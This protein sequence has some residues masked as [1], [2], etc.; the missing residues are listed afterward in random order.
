MRVRLTQFCV[1]LLFLLIPL[2]FNS[3][4]DDQQGA[5]EAVNAEQ[6]DESEYDDQEEGDEYAEDE[7][8]GDEYAEDEEG[9][10]YAEGNEE[11]GNEYANEEEGAGLDAYALAG[12]LSYQITDKATFNGRIDYARGKSGVFFVSDDGAAT[13]LLSVTGTVDYSLWENVISRLEV[14]WD[15]AL[16]GGSPFGGFEET[17]FSP[18]QEENAVTI[19]LNAIYQF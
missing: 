11:G 7:E 4:A 9:N 6:G 13:E 1:M 14:R 5:Q 18:G 16:D 15:H 17:F 3:C 2:S 8:G 12:Y 19:A 10:E